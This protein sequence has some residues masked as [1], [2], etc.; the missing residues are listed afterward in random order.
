[1]GRGLNTHRLPNSVQEIKK[2]V[3]QSYNMQ[4]YPSNVAKTKVTMKRIYWIQEV[5]AI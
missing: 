2:T 4:Q 5:L 3:E 1:M